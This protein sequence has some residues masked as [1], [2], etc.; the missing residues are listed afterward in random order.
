VE[1]ILAVFKSA[2]VKSFGGAT[3]GMAGLWATSWAN[4]VTPF[5]QVGIT[6]GIL[7]G[8]WLGIWWS[9]V[10]RRKKQWAEKYGQK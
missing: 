6:L 7:V 5:L 4:A 1:W 2:Q 8:T 10:D 3:F 9:I